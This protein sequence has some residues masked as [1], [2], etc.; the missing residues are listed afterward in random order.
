MTSGAGPLAQAWVDPLNEA[1]CRA[2]DVERVV[3]VHGGI[4][5]IGPL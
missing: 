2:E 1:W 4:N 5:P 3:H